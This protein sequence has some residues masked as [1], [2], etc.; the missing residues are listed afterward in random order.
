MNGNAKAKAFLAAYRLTA[1][2]THAA[3]AA[4]I[5]RALH[6]RWLKQSE[7]YAADFKAA[8]A[9]ATDVLV[10]EATRRAN[11]GV[12]EPVFFQGAP[13]GAVRR[14]DSHLMHVL[15]RARNPERFGA[16]TEITGKDGGA[17]EASI[18]VTFVKP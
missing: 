10:D 5:D 1:S 14:Y 2:I 13:C 9:E 18:Q 11:E 8:Y 15:L 17:I 6:Y 7:S 3:A 16:K 12:L 4:K